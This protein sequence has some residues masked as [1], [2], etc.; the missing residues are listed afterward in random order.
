V[1]PFEIL[2]VLPYGGGA[3]ISLAGVFYFVSRARGRTDWRTMEPVEANQ[4][5][6]IFVLR[7]GKIIEANFPGRQELQRICE[8]GDDETRLR[9]LLSI[10]FGKPEILLA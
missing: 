2:S 7:N 10:R 1:V 8:T 9:S 6:P 3:L 5:N 4:G